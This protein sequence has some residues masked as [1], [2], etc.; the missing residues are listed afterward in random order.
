MLASAAISG[1]R[2]S[3]LIGQGLRFGMV[4][5]VT[6]LITLAIIAMT[7]PALG[8][9]AANVVGYLLG[10][11][12][13][14][15]ANRRLTFGA[16]RSDPWRGATGFAVVT[17]T[18]LGLDLLVIRVA[19]DAGATALVAQALGSVTYSVFCFAGLKYHVFKA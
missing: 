15:L 13:S 11:V 10:M 18:C 9:M 4:G 2:S 1:L 3:G 6:T 7:A 5:G 8:L 12:L 17:L 14:F 16:G 19:L